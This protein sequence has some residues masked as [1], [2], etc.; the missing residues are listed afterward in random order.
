MRSDVELLH[1][2]AGGDREA[3]GELFRRHFVA[4]F[5]FFSNKVGAAAEDLTQQ[6]FLACVESPQNFRGEGVFRA[7][8]L[9]TARNVLYKEYRRRRRKDDRLDFTSKSAHDLGPS[10]SAVLEDKAQ[11]RTV[12]EA[13][14][15]I[16]VDY[17]I[18]IELYLWEDLTAAQMAEILELTEPGV[19]SRLRRAKTALARELDAVDAGPSLDS[20]T[21][22]L[23]SWA[24]SLRRTLRERTSSY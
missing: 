2:W 1:G 19:R 20:T 6:T 5:R 16:P 12:L 22:D 17:Q 13:L 7:Y 21:S 15:R 10:P 14:R 23:E 3:G 8:L 24:E 11:R 4:V 9:A 18:A